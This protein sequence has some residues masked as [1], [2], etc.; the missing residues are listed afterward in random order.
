MGIS[1]QC[2]LSALT[3]SRVLSCMGCYRVIFMIFISRHWFMRGFQ[4]ISWFIC[5]E[6]QSHYFK[7]RKL[8]LQ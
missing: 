1:R 8:L 6:D 3:I 4:I 2:C 7:L 5:R